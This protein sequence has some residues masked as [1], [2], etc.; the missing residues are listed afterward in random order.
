M[1][2][3]ERIRRLENQLQHN[4]CV[5]IADQD[6]IDADPER[7]RE[8]IHHVERDA[9]RR[10]LKVVVLTDAVPP[11]I[12]PEGTLVYDFDAEHEN[13][14]PGGIERLLHYTAWLR[15]GDDRYTPPHVS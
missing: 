2:L 7:W 8:Y 4:A 12:S 5:V 9:R 1:N 6:T 15:S 3:R 11:S 13:H 14:T 10:G